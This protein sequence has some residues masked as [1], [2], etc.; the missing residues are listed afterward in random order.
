M[1][2]ALNLVADAPA[3][4]WTGS[5]AALAW[6]FC[7]D[8]IA[9]SQRASTEA[10]VWRGRER[11]LGLALQP[12]FP[13]AAGVIW[14]LLPSDHAERRSLVQSAIWA[15]CR[16]QRLIST[17]STQLLMSPALVAKPRRWETN[18]SLSVLSYPLV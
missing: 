11:T 5:A 18:F 15:R 3:G 2:S 9:N 16:V 1:P 8:P 17:R 10:R 7:F 12:F 4:S 13:H 14:P 6:E